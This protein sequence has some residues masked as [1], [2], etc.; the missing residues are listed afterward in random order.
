MQETTMKKILIQVQKEFCAECS[1]AIMRFMQNMEGIESVTAED[2]WVSIA[3]DESR[4]TE[5]RVEQIA[6]ENIEKLGYRVYT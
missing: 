1:L 5:E 3:F 6:R 4:V 2:G